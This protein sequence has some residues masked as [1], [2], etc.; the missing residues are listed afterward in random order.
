MFRTLFH[1]MVVLCVSAAF[2]VGG[3]SQGQADTAAEIDSKV[4]AALKILYAGEESAKVLGEKA[5]EILV[6]PDII[7]AGL[8]IGGQYGEGA[9]RD[10]SNKTTGYYNTVAASYG[11]QI[12]VQKFGYAMFLMNDDAVEHVKASDG[13][14]VGTGPSIVVMDKGAAG[15]MTTTTY[16]DDI[17]V[18]FFDQ[19]GLMA[20]LGIQG[21][22][23]SRIQPDK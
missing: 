15:S 6:F 9:M 8:M 14:E 11:L 7:K 1:V 3:S 19:S 21:T 20:G 16:K 2:V 5:K 10:K 4:T 12:G 18:F 17:Y 13:W 23:V 22:K